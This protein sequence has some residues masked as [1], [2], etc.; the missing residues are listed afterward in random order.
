[1]YINYYIIYKLDLFLNFGDLVNDHIYNKIYHDWV[2]YLNFGE[3]TMVSFIWLMRC[4]NQLNVTRIFNKSRLC[5]L[6]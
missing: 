2:T 1:M 5:M 3:K 4:M 6:G